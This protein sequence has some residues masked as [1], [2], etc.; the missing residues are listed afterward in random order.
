VRDFSAA[1]TSAYSR[2]DV[3]INNAGVMIP[4]FTLTKDGFELQI[5]TNHFG[6]FLLVELLTPLLTATA[7]RTGDARI[8]AVSS[9]AHSRGTIDFDDI[10]WSTR[11][12]SHFGAY[13]QSKLANVVHA[14]ELSRRLAGTGVTAYSLHPGV[15]TTELTRHVPAGDVL[16]PLAAP[17]TAI[18]F[19][20]AWEGAQTQ[21]LLALA[22]KEVV[23]GDSGRYFSDCEVMAPQASEAFDPVVGRRLWDASRKAVGLQAA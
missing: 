15:V 17:I 5:G 12:Y 9:R 21:L 10:N 2:L 14:A 11:P 22:P 13:A 23:A 18:F 7:K 20:D 8:V 6:H 1:F 3:L 16:I 19:K 4:P